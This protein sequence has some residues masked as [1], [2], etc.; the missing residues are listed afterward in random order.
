MAFPL[1]GLV[2]YWKLD[3][4]SGSRADSYGSNTLTDNNTVTS[5]PGQGGNLGTVAAQFT[6][7]NSEYLSAIDNAGLSPTAAASVQAWVYLD[8][9]ANNTNVV[10][11][12]WLF[13]T[14]GGWVFNIQSVDMRSFV[15]DSPTDGGSNVVDCNNGTLN[16]TATWYLV[17][18]VYDG[19]LS[20]ANRVQFYINGSAQSMSV[21]A[22]TIPAVLQDPAAIFALGQWPGLGRFYNGRMQEVGFWNVALSAGEVSDLWNGGA[23]L[24]LP[25]T[26][27]I[28][29]LALTGV[30]A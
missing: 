29:E 3:E 25:T 17:H 26:Q 19:S 10:A 2:S 12:H 7:A 16:A 30:G 21:I 22:G 4:V 11:S 13:A 5:N 15:A 27:Q 14:A 24:A 6:A 9:L 20:A 18:W 1:T 28:K 23:G 8:T